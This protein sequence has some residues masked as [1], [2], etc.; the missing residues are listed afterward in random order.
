MPEFENLEPFI[1]DKNGDHMTPVA[2]HHELAHEFHPKRAKGQPKVAR[3][4]LRPRKV[5]LS[6]SER[7]STEQ[8]ERDF[9]AAIKA[10]KLRDYRKGES[11]LSRLFR[12]LKGWITKKLKKKARA[13]R[14]GDQKRN[15]RPRGDREDRERPGGKRGD[16]DQ[17]DKR[18]DRDKRGKRDKRGGRGDRKDAPGGTD[19]SKGGEARPRKKNR[20]RRADGRGPTPD[21]QRAAKKHET[22]QPSSEAPKP[23]PPQEDA[24]SA[25]KPSGENNPSASRGAENSDREKKSKRNR[26]NRNRRP[27]GGGGNTSSD[28]RSPSSSSSDY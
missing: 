26:R 8:M 7:I 4:R 16:R 21:A 9:K 15:P 25:I 5:E 10:E 3:E 1:D 14:K 17:R 22:N 6:E 24:P 20:D 27:G 12:K 19:S 18:G 11:P 13:S 28:D 23:Q 2:P